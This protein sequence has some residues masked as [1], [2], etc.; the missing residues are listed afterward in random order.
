MNGM[1]RNHRIPAGME[2]VEPDGITELVRG[3][4]ARLVE[5]IAPLARVRPVLLDLSGV[6]R[7]DAAGVA[8][9]I[10]LYRMACEAGCRFGV[11]NPRPHVA[12]ILALVGLDR[13]LLAEWVEEQSPCGAEFAQS[14]A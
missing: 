8:A 12:E 4:E 3:N 13:I 14:A 10:T 1:E 2:A 6:E 9:L 11:I 5:R 7:I